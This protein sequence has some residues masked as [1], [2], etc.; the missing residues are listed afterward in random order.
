MGGVLRLL[1]IAVTG[2]ISSGKSTVCDMMANHGA[3]VISAD[4]IVHRLLKSNKTVQ[5]QIN[6]LLNTHISFSDSS[7]REQIAQKI[8]NDKSLL[9]KFEN[10][11]HPLVIEQ[12]D[13]AYKTCLKAKNY[14]YFVCEV[15]LLFEIGFE[16]FFDKTIYVEA[17]ESECIQR[18]VL[19][20]NGS[21]EDWRTRMK[22]FFPSEVSRQK[23]S[24]VITNKSSYQDLEN[25]VIHILQ[26]LL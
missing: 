18:F 13:E 4:D 16:T 19:K 12:I 25:Q 6:Q 2:Q 15:P 26:S 22:R 3:Y 5:N 23:A 11:L 17:P 8:F 9:L 24:F 14:R 21:A 20:T 10:L 1:K 7:Y